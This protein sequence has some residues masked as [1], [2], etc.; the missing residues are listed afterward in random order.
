MYNSCDGVKEVDRYPGTV[1]ALNA[2]IRQFRPNLNQ[3]TL[4]QELRIP[5]DELKAMF[6]VNDPAVTT[7]SEQ[8]MIPGARQPDI[9]QLH[10]EASR[11]FNGDDHACDDF[12]ATV[13]VANNSRTQL[14]TTTEDRVLQCDPFSTFELKT[15]KR[16]KGYD[17]SGG[18]KNERLTHEN[19]LPPLKPPRSGYEDDSPSTPSSGGFA[20]F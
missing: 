2:I 5:E 9:I 6:I 16:L 14:P 8:F 15:R 20:F 3:K 17:M 19:T 12:E 13:F 7:E 4:P 11:W 18:Y 1:L 10:W